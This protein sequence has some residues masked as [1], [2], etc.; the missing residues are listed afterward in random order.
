MA[1][2]DYY[3]VLGVLQNA[4]Q[5]EIKKAY[6]RQAKQH[7][8]DRNRGEKSAEE[9]FKEVSEAYQVLSDPQKKQHYDLFGHN[10]FRNGSGY[11]NRNPHADSTGGYHRSSGPY[12]SGF[13]AEDLNGDGARFEDIFNEIFGGA[14]RYRRP[15]QGFL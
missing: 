10:G 6:K 4:T 5:D 3:Q 12:T 9:R 1:N 2:R 8:P 13:A 14:W 11:G 15:D 7:H